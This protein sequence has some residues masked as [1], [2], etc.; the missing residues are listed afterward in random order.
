[1]IVITVPRKTDIIKGGCSISTSSQCT[2]MNLKRLS[3]EVCM[4]CWSQNLSID[5]VVELRC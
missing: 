2:E 3:Y 5:H 1:M 4:L